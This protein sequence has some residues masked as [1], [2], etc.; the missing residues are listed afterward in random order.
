MKQFLL[1]TGVTPFADLFWG[2]RKLESPRPVEQHVDSFCLF[3]CVA[4]ESVC[5]WIVLN[6]VYLRGSVCGYVRMRM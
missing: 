2:T 1:Q 3:Y 4:F 5:L 6:Y